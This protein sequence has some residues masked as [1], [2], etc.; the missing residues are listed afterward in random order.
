MK[1]VLLLLSLFPLLSFAQNT[2]GQVFYEE[3]INIEVKLPGG[4]AGDA[5]KQSL[6]S[7]KKLSFKKEVSVLVTLPQEQVPDAPDLG[8]DENDFSIKIDVTDNENRIYHNLNDKEKLEETDFFGKTFLIKSEIE[9]LAWKIQDEQKEIL[10]YTCMKATLETEKGLTEA[11]FTPQIPLA[12]GPNKGGLPGLI[13][14]LS[15][16]DG[17]TIR[18]ATAINL[19]PVDEA[20]LAM[21]KKGKKISAE[22]FK[23]LEEAKVKELEQMY[24]GGKKNKGNTVIKIGG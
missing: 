10:G 2:E 11:W 5:F 9:P 12:H 20:D 14:A 7:K 21:P 4:V 19:D 1:T 24:G 8:A 15:M 6:K 23:A 18:M 13:L 17:Q 22:K 16:R 3:T